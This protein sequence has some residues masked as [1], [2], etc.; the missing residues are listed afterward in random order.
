[1]KDI[2][3]HNQLFEEGKVSYK[4]AVNAFTDMVN[5]SILIKLGRNKNKLYSN[6]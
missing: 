6:S 5:I 2:E 4:M 3:K 1:M